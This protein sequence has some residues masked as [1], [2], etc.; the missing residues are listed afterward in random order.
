MNSGSK[1]VVVFAT[2][3]DIKQL[4][5][6]IENGADHLTW[7]L[8]F[9]DSMEPSDLLPRSANAEILRGALVLSVSEQIPS[10]LRQ[11]LTQLSPETNIH[12][13][14]FNETTGS[15]S[16]A[17]I[18]EF[19]L[20]AAY[21]IDATY[22]IVH[23][24]HNLMTR[25]CPDGKVCSDFLTAEPEEFYDEIAKASFVG[26]NSNQ[27]AFLGGSLVQQYQI[28]NYQ[29]TGN[30]FSMVE[31]GTHFLHLHSCTLYFSIV[32]LIECRVS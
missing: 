6:V 1:V 16:Q 22:A 7:I 8:A 27:V 9:P 29:R 32:Y 17:A 30:S 25:L 10:D 20:K 13:P 4:L 19:G 2:S 21:I 15:F 23:G 24:I 28:S 5:S 11:H 3:S 18:S 31:V 26:I 12:N 14:W